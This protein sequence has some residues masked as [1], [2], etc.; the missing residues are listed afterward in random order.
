[1]CGINGVIDYGADLGRVEAALSAMERA[2]LHRGPDGHGRFTDSLSSACFVGLGHQRLAILDTSTH[3]HQPM[4]SP[5]GRYV[6]VYNG[7]VYNYREIAEDLR[8]DPV[9][10]SSSGDTAVVLAALMRWGADALKRFNGMWALLLL[11]RKEKSLL[12]AR[13]RLG[14]KPLYFHMDA[15]RLWFASEVKSIL[16]ATQKRFGLNRRSIAQYLLQSLTDS[17][18]DTFFEDIHSIPPGHYWE[19]PL[20]SRTHRR[21]DMRPYWRHPYDECG[22]FDQSIESPE[23]LRQLF[24]DSVKLRLRSDVPVGVLLSG[25]LDSSCMLAAVKAA[26][27]LDHVTALSV[28]SDD[29]D[30]NEEPF[31]DIMANHAGCSVKKLKID[32]SPLDVLKDLDQTCWYM[33]QPVGGFSSV[34]HRRLMQCAQDIGVTVLLTGQG[35]DEQLGGYNKFFYFYLIDCVRSH[36]YHQA[37]S[38]LFYSLVQGTILREFTW[39]EAKRY[40]PALRTI[41]GRSYLN[42][43]LFAESLAKT[44]M[45]GSYREREWLDIRYFSVPMLLHYE[46][47]MSMSLAKEM[48]VPFLDYRV[49]EFLARVP[50]KQKLFHGWTKYILRMAMA[51][52]VPDA[53]RWRKDKK[54]FN[55]PEANWA[56]GEFISHFNARFQDDM[57]AGRLGFVVPGEVRRLY[58]RYVKGD[59][60][61]AYKNIFSIYCLETWLRVFEPYIEFN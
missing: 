27:A 29:P 49:V 40:I 60:G 50:P 58:D 48:R 38:M 61:V 35:S 31:I 30:S 10:A 11:D 45:A 57:L 46:D 39:A 16:S 28:V 1:M 44:G 54:G 22:E 13:D 23:Q 42:S 51:G 7:E 59:G 3:A 20:L 26:G 32:Q 5:D 53:I 14:I 6:L 37:A 34:A 19:I 18:E 12:V 55:L 47:R 21:E 8:D 41:N 15:E 52:Y 4:L 33:D 17:S 43:E 36:R 25:G 9:I 24:F 56:R 2:Q